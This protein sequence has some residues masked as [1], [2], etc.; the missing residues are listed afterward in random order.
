MMGQS[1]AY[2]RGFFTPDPNHYVG[3]PPG[4]NAAGQPI[5]WANFT[6]PQPNFTGAGTRPS[7]FAGATDATGRKLAG[8]TQAQFDQYMRSLTGQLGTAGIPQRLPAQPIFPSFAANPQTQPVPT[9]PTSPIQ[10]P[11]S[12][13]VGPTTP[14][15][16]QQVASGSWAQPR[17]ASPLQSPMNQ[18]QFPIFPYYGQP[19]QQAAPQQPVQGAGNRGTGNPYWS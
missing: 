1:S 13:P 18:F 7:D 16:I 17:M 8:M 12:A 6:P 4:L 3:L 5:S 2:P 11:G 14:A 10:P 19:R 15:G 9:S